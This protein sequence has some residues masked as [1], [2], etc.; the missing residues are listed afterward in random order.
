MLHVRWAEYVAVDAI[1]KSA[2]CVDENLALPLRLTTFLNFPAT[3]ILIFSITKVVACHLHVNVQSPVQET[4]TA[5]EHGALSLAG[6]PKFLLGSLR[7][8]ANHLLCAQPGRPHRLL[9][10][11]R[12]DVR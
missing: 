2:I 8:D 6:P 1:S 9:P 10:V 12:L 3:E 5:G 11:E 4:R 7:H